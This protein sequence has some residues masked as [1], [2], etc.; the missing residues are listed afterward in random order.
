MRQ[1]ESLFYLPQYRESLLDRIT[2]AYFKRGAEQPQSPP[3]KSKSRG[4]A[5]GRDRG[6]ANCGVRLYYNAL[7]MNER[8][9]VLI[10]QSFANQDQELEE[11]SFHP[12]LSLS[13]V[14]QDK[15]RKLRAKVGTFNLLFGRAN[16]KQMKV[17]ELR[18]VKEEKELRTLRQKPE[19]NKVY[20][21]FTVSSKL[22]VKARRAL[23]LPE[24]KENVDT[25]S[26]LYEESRL[27]EERRKSQVEMQ[28]KK[29]S[30]QPEINKSSLKKVKLLGKGFEDRM[31]MFEELR[32]LKLSIE[33]V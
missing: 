9:K 3:A 15:E 17:E 12:D 24:G 33:A 4:G 30:F 1:E 5:G 16:S 27:K 23:F 20:R 14:V 29:Y 7:K 8:K 26:L 10:N 6:G 22:I 11:C 21:P 28:G 13:K 31:L 19:I 32:Q 2:N 18:L 25:S